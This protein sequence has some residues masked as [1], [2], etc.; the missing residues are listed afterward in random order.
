MKIEFYSDEWFLEE[1]K[2][3]NILLSSNKNIDSD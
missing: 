1:I 3:T 2:K